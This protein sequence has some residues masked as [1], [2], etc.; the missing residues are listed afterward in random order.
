MCVCGGEKQISLFLWW[1]HKIIQ[2]MIDMDDYKWP[3]NVPVILHFGE[4]EKW[5]EMQWW[6]KD[7]HIVR[8]EHPSRQ[9]GAAWSILR[10]ATQWGLEELAC[11]GQGD[12]AGDVDILGIQVR[13]FW[14][15]MLFINMKNWKFLFGWLIRLPFW[16]R[17]V[18]SIHIWVR[19]YFT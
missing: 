7:R 18:G 14:M 6:R 8:R 19:V 15:R 17:N 9:V 13:R 1:R 10:A 16:E 11:V 5:F 4:D 12:C 3:Q 2:R